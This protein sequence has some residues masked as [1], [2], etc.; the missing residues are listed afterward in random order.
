VS[1]TRRAMRGMTRRDGQYLPGPIFGLARAVF[2]CGGCARRTLPCRAT[3][4]G[5]KAR[6]RPGWDEDLCFVHRR[7]LPRWPNGSASDDAAVLR[8]FNPLGRCSWCLGE[9]R[10]ALELVTLRG[11]AVHTCG[12]C[13]RHTHR[14]TSCHT[15]FSRTGDAQ[16]ARCLGLIYDWHATEINEE[17]TRRNGWCSWCGELCAHLVRDAR[18]EYCQCLVCGGGTAACQQCPGVMRTRS[19]PAGLGTTA[20]NGACAGGWCMRCDVRHAAPRDEVGAVWEAMLTRRAAADQAAPY[21]LDTLQRSSRYK[22]RA[23]NAGIVRQGL[24]LIPF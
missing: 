24:P 7:L 15:A 9:K 17:L 23:L 6:G 18:H 12:G 19:R 10:H 22:T 3:G 16:C 14:C 5:A 8:R 4:C 11:A 21:I 1:M 2:K 13:S 20:G